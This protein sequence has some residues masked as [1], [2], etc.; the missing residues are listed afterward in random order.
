MSL[1]NDVFLYAKS[2]QN[3]PLGNLPL[4]C[5]PSASGGGP[6]IYPLAVT[7]VG[8]TPGGLTVLTTDIL[9]ATPITP[10]DRY[11]LDVNALGYLLD[12]ASGDIVAIPVAATGDAEAA[13]ATKVP[14]RAS[15]L[16]YNGTTWDRQRSASAANLAAQSGLGAVLAAPPGQWSVTHS[17]A[18]N[19]QATITKAAGAA[20]V[21]HVATSI[22]ATLSTNTAAQSVSVIV[23]LRDGATGAG[24][25][26]WSTRLTIDTNVATIGGAPIAGIALSG[27][28]IPGSAATAMTLE[29]AANGGA[30]IFES[31]ALTGYDA[32]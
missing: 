1:P 24:T 16:V 8:D 19:N 7:L 28:N 12:V 32:S 20:G 29:F 17:P 15:S 14:V 10:D 25:I 13:G 21:R 6:S 5:V 23:N 31:V 27:L 3:P 4:S 9:G 22:T 30:N 26:L 18:A 11:V 2:D